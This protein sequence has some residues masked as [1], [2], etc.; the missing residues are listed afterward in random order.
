M[1]KGRK[2]L[3][4]SDMSHYQYGAWNPSYLDFIILKATEGRTFVDDRM[5]DFIADMAEEVPDACPF[6]G[7]YHY[8]RAESNSPEDEAYHF[9]RTIKPHIGNCFCALDYEGTALNNKS[10]DEW[11]YD[12]CTIVEAETDTKPLLYISASYAQRFMKTLAEYP[13]WVAHYN[14]Q[15]PKISSCHKPAIWQFTSKP[16]DVDL[17]YGDKADMVRLIRGE[18]K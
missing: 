6:I 12:W 11:A 16:F 4:G 17:F 15:T 9:I 10:R 3:L 2:I 1:S 7:F 5:N 18:Y 13:L 8:A 14:V